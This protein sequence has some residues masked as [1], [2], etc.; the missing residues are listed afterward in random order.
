MELL[1]DLELVAVEYENQ[2]QK[3]VLTYLD[4][5]HGEI[6][7]VNFNKQA[8]KNGSY[9]DDDEK[10]QKVEEWCKE[11]FNLKFKDLTKALHTT[12]DV[13]AYDNFNSLFEVK[14]IAKFSE[15]MVGQII[16][17]EITDV[18][19]DDTAI[20]IQFEHE[21]ETY[22]SKMSYAKYMEFDKKFYIDPIKKEKQCQKFK[23]KFGVPVEEADKIIGHSCIV[24]VKKAMGKYV[25]AEMKQFPK[26]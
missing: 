7:T 22:E 10:A 6:R 2:G 14:Q 8:Y 9:V 20:H 18:I 12:H 19:I 24:E 13:Y 5:E 25:Y 17:S 1:K 21:G 3:A 16:Q 4:R 11:I 26:K 15:D 23:E